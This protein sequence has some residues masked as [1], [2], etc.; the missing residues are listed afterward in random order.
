ML[1]WVPKEIQKT[2]CSVDA[3]MVSGFCL[4][5]SSGDLKDILAAFER[6]G[7]KCFEDD[8]LVCHACGL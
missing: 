7:F 4:S 2:Y 6:Y 5:F 3:S 1:E 8:E